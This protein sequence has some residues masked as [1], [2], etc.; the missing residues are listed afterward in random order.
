MR[1][2]FIVIVILI[3]S[4]TICL[5]HAQSNNELKLNLGKTA[6]GFAEISY[7][8]VLSQ[9]FGVGTALAVG[10]PPYKF[11]QYKFA[12]TPFARYYVAGTSAS[13]RGRAAGLFIEANGFFFTQDYKEERGEFKIE[14]GDP[15]YIPGQPPHYP[16]EVIDTRHNVYLHKT[17]IGLGGAVGYKY[18]S[19]RLWVGE[20]F[21]GMGKNFTVYKDNGFYPN[22]GLSVGKRF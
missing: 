5:L 4:G 19:R 13:E 7:E 6:F 17:G 8:N 2:T 1:K 16:N 21:V 11:M 18:T 9:R 3:L 14:F 12:L 22:I 15:I 20:I 10:I